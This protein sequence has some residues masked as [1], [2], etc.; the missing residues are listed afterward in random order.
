ML[1]R[2][3]GQV[4]RFSDR[5]LTRFGKLSRAVLNDLAA[6]DRASEKILDSLLA[7]RRGALRWSRL[8]IHSYL[9]ARDL[10]FEFVR[11]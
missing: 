5:L 2:S 9:E 1:W 6:R 4:N 11:R 10:P 3:Q 7:Y 8:S